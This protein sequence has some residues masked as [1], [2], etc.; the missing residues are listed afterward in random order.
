[1]WVETIRCTPLCSLVNNV[2][3]NI[4]KPSVEYTGDEYDKIMKT[5]LDSCFE[6]CRL[7]YPLLKASGHASVI[8]I[9]SVAGVV[10]MRTGMS[11]VTKTVGI[12]FPVAILTS[13][14]TE[15]HW[16]CIVHTID[17]FHD[18]GVVYAMTKAA[19]NQM[20]KVQK[21]LV[22]KRSHFFSCHCLC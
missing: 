17:A 18:A 7:A 12:M 16:L 22:A 6:F 4:R 3:T 20:T 1:V 2:G 8:N 14:C 21:A 9:T 5:N 19:L 10:A 13:S 15:E 11:A